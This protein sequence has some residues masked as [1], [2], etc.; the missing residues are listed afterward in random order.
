MKLHAKLMIAPLLTSG[1]LILSLVLSV[2]GS[3]A[4]QSSN[5]SER[6]STVD[7]YTAAGAI[8]SD[9]SEHRTQLYRTVA[10]IGSLSG[11]EVDATRQR[12]KK[13][14]AEIAAAVKPLLADQSAT[15]EVARHFAELLAHYEKSADA[16]ID[17]ST[18]DPNTGIAALQTADA[19][20]VAL[21]KDLKSIVD[22]V[23]QRHAEQAHSLET[24]FSRASIGMGV[25]G[26][27]AAA[28]MLAFAW[29]TQR[30]I[31]A[32]ISQAADAAA[33]VAQGDLAI[34]VQAR[35]EDEVGALLQSLSNMVTQ[36][37]GSIHTVR[38]AA[39]SIGLASSEIAAG[40]Q[41]LSS[42]TEHTAS[43]LQQTASSMTQ[44]TG[45]VRH[46]ADSARTANQLASSAAEAASRGG[47]VVAQVVANMDDINTASRKINE[48][49][50][51]IDG[52]AFQTNIL[53]L[54]A[55]VE[56][57]RAGEQGRGFAVVAG[58][59]RNLAQRSAN[60]A[61]EIKSLIT[62]STERIESGSKLVQDAGSTMQE[63]VSSV[64]RVSDII[65]E[66][67]AATSDQSNGIGQVN[68]AVSQLDQLTQQN[69]ALVEESAA[70]AESLK[71][72][73]NRLTDVVGQFRLQS[74]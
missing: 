32:D 23:N 49:I 35:G 14:L 1:A 5:A 63:I 9:L 10:L 29:F 68:T 53:A 45:T 54:N 40:N 28:G 18:V 25:L 7:A 12:L 19:D 30:K 71:D 50:G 4:Y 48:I 69:A 65:G 56:A 55:A 21:T 11:A 58:E 44:L 66:I 20:F 64:Q 24:L 2:A 22:S 60:A 59:V 47:N 73:A 43:S 70:A 67:T 17:L 3:Q 72:Q 34:Q 42:R 37:S 38:Q 61:K 26:L 13:D 31:V 27:T 36:L 74:H 62:A 16:A 46:T 52:I 57:A 8:R 51:V 6:Q 41:D 39:Q 15:A 33:Q